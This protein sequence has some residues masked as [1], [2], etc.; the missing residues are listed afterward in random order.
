MWYLW[1]QEESFISGFYRLLVNLS[2]KINL[3]KRDVA[4]SSRFIKS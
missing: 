2:E 1:T 3:K 4:L